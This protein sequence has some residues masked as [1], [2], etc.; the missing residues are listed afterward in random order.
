MTLQWRRTKGGKVMRDDLPTGVGRALLD[1]L[2]QLY[3]AQLGSL[4]LDAPIWVSFSRNGS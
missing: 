3:G 2:H 1:Y 4:P